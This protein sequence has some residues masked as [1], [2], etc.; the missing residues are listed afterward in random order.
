MRAYSTKTLQL[1]VVSNSE[2][3]LFQSRIL[4][5]A[6][7]TLYK[8]LEILENMYCPE[9]TK[10]RNSETETIFQKVMISKYEYRDNLSKYYFPRNIK[11]YFLSFGKL[12]S[13][14]MRIY[15]ILCVH[16][17]PSF[18]FQRDICIYLVYTRLNQFLVFLPPSNSFSQD[19]H[20]YR[21]CVH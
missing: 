2:S 16:L 7:K 17:I 19:R 12:F 20:V 18:F 11:S 6:T 5:S 9:K 3:G 13:R 15:E 14:T 4:I 8:E 1:S 10:S 21:S